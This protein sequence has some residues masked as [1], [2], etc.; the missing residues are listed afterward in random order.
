MH[1]VAH[2]VGLTHVQARTELM[3]SKNNGQLTFGPG[4][5]EGLRQLG[6]GPCFS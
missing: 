2:L 5:L 6:G 4:D 1:E 3:Y